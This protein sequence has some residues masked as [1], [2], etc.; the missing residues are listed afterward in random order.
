[1]SSQQQKMML[2][3][4]NQVLRSLPGSRRKTPA[5]PRALFLARSSGTSNFLRFRR[6]QPGTS[7]R[8]LGPGRH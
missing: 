3:I 7:A 2:L 8:S 4:P 5:R 1:M 6:L